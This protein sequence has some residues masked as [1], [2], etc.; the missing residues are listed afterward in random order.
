M[1]KKRNAQGL[2]I[3][4]IVIAVIAL[5]V[6]V[7]LITI[8]TGKLGAFGEGV[9]GVATCANACKALGKI[10]DT[11]SGSCSGTSLPGDYTEG[12]NCCCT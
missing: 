5:I 4:T 8:L 6:L 11:S 3:T 10:V 1:I 9:S 12:S 2:S 7:V